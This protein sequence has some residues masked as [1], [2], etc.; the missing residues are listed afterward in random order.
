MPMESGWA[1]EGLKSKMDHWA[2]RQSPRNGICVPGV[3]SQPLAHTRVLTSVSPVGP[4][5]LFSPNRGPSGVV[6]P[7]TG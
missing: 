5:G 4:G 7:E 1:Q 6:S 3:R 2:V